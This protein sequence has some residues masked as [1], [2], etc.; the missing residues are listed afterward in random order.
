M[1]GPHD[2]LGVVGLELWEG[3]VELDGDR[4]RALGRGDERDRRGDIETSPT[5]RRSRRPTAPIAPSKQA[6]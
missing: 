3:D 4:E 5:S 6:A 1:G 2:P